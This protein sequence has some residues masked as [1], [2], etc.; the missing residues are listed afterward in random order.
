M[1]NIGLELMT[2]LGRLHFFPIRRI[3][4]R[5]V[6]PFLGVSEAGRPCLDLD[7][8]GSTAPSGWKSSGLCPRGAA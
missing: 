1:P 6:D 2:L 7:V 4:E 8:R 3:Q 5:P